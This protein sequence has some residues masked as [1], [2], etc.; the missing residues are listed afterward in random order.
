VTPPHF[1]VGDNSGQIHT[2]S[3]HNISATLLLEME[4]RSAAPQPITVLRRLHR[5]FVPPTGFEE[6]RARLAERRTLF[7]DC[8]AGHTTA[9]CML[10]W[11]PACGERT[12]VELQAQDRSEGDLFE[13]THIDDGG[14]HLLDLRRMDAEADRLPLALNPL[15]HMAEQRSAQLV[16]LLPG[17]KEPS[18][19]RAEWYALRCSLPAPDPVDVLLAWLGAE[20]IAV[21]PDFT[22]IRLRGRPLTDIVRIAE[23]TV[24]ARK[25]EPGA[26][27]SRWY[28]EGYKA[29]VGRGDDS[30]D[31]IAGL[32]G[33]QRALM[34]S[35]AML[36]G[37]HADA[38]ESATELLLKSAKQQLDARSALEQAPLLGRL[39]AVG[40]ELDDENRV[41]FEQLRRDDAVRRFFWTHMPELRQIQADWIAELLGSEKLA[42]EEGVELVERFADLMLTPRHGPVLIN[43]V[44]EWHTK[45]GIQAA[46]LLLQRGAAHSEV[47]RM[48]RRCVYDWA[49]QPDLSERRTT[50]ILRACEEIMRTHPDE[51]VVRLHH[52]VRNERGTRGLEVLSEHVRRERRFLRQ[53]LR[54]ITWSADR[55]GG[56]GRFAAADARLFLAVADPEALTEDGPGGALVSE[57][58]IRHQ[59]AVG[60]RL[61]FALPDRAWTDL[62]RR[63][64]GHVATGPYGTALLRILT[65]T[66]R[67]DFA[68]R[69]DLYALARPYG[70]GVADA[71]LRRVGPGKR[72]VSNA[73]EARA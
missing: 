35:V 33:E 18:W 65:E 28:E 16:F 62:A 46:G 30:V 17:G 1:E 64:I 43:L 7:L 45:I 38:V 60:W 24:E 51:A 10:L 53:I 67:G 63:W 34:L 15:M 41:R 50:L 2:G 49:C 23:A 8:A 36:H 27:F 25:R 57:A 68:V 58:E 20:G 73:E 44:K 11:S 71:F 42:P 29:A 6:A 47:G 12:V 48:I 4:R 70:P 55:A 9:A 13:P 3:G 19:F 66:A 40:A 69:A 72:R 32:S 61:A 31:L 21:E 26:G 39:A 14:L 5:R 54:R 22:D 37:A 52:L 56:S 59:S